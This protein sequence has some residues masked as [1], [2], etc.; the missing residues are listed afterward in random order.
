MG[1]AGSGYAVT[2]QPGEVAAGGS[3]RVSA[4]K[5][6]TIIAQGNALGMAALE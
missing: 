4:P 3:Q 2:L 6:R 1:E 5:E